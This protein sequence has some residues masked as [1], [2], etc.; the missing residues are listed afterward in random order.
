MNP[1]LARYSLPSRPPQT[2]PT[3]EAPREFPYHKLETDD[4]PAYFDGLRDVI[5]RLVSAS[6]LSEG[7]KRAI[8]EDLLQA[9]SVLEKWWPTLKRK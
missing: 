3:C 8:Q 7:G 4:W 2:L 6:D 9:V 1:S 5:R